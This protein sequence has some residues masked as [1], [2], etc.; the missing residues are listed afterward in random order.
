MF[1]P[2][3]VVPLRALKTRNAQKMCHKQSLFSDVSPEKLF[4]LESHRYIGNKTKLRS[5]IM[6]TI[7]AETADAH[8]FIDMFAG[9]ARIA[10]A[11]CS[12]TT[13]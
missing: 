5:W 2:L 13:R 6:E 7:L 10:K 9:T 4:S 11:A 1:T 8:S 12:I 3:F